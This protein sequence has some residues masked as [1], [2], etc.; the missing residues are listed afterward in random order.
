MAIRAIILDVG[1][2]IV[3]ERDQTGRSK[4]EALLGLPPGQLTRLVFGTEAAAGAALG[5]VTERMVWAQVGRSLGLTDEQTYEL[6]RDFWSS[7]QLDTTFVQ[8][9]QGLRPQHRIAILSNAWSDAR[10]IHKD[11]FKFD[12]WVDLAVYSA[13]VKLLKPDPQIYQLVLSGLE[14][15]AEECIFVDDKLENVQ[16]AQALGMHGIWFRDARQTIDDI[17]GCLH[18]PAVI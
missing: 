3:H 14:L 2:V 10:S 16:A 9:I 6:Q 12:S 11:K 17:K 13:E 1:G 5:Q 8:F 15:A 7:E 4:W 18:Q